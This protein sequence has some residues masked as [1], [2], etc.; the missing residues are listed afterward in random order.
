MSKNYN[1]KCMHIRMTSKFETKAIS[2][3][4]KLKD[5]VIYKSKYSHSKLFL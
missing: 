4:F 3:K 2:T 1:S 5:K